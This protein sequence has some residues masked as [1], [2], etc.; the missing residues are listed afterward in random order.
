MWDKENFQIAER[1]EE[2]TQS[3]RFWGSLIRIGCKTFRFYTEQASALVACDYII[4]QRKKADFERVALAL[5]HQMVNERKT[6]NETDARMEIEKDILQLK[7]ICKSRIREARLE[8]ERAILTNNTEAAR[9]LAM[10]QGQLQDQ[11]AASEAA[12]KSMSGDM[13]TLQVQSEN[14]LREKLFQFV[15]AR[16]AARSTTPF[17]KRARAGSTRQAP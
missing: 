10:M 1:R 2:L 16:W 4:G 3:T 5:Q 7:Q 9:A 15:K 11:I 6:L 14:L 17:R 8:A 13:M 12:L